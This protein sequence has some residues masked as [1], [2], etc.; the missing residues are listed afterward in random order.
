V[1]ASTQN[2]SPTAAAKTAAT[3]PAAAPKPVRAKA[4]RPQPAPAA[5][6]RT[7]KAT[8]AAQDAKAESPAPAKESAKSADKNSN[9]RTI[10]VSIPVTVDQ[11]VSVTAF[12]ANVPTSV[13]RR[14][15]SAK[16]GL[17]VYLGLGGLAVVGIAEW[18]VAAAAGVGLAVLRRWGPLRPASEPAAQTEQIKI[19]EDAVVITDAAE[20]A[21]NT[22]D[23]T[24]V[25]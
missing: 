20:P 12:V 14:V 1:P 19:D 24:P 23:A 9:S 2:A 3:K 15:A 4:V 5:K 6:P 18:P 11:I 25:G 13:V 7:A 16:N 17:P 21:A 22:A 10:T 8:Q